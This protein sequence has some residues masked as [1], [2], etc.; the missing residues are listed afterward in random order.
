MATAKGKS[1]TRK[2][3]AEARERE[4]DNIFK[5]LG[6]VVSSTSHRDTIV[7]AK[8]ESIRPD[9]E[10]GRLGQQSLISALPKITSQI[11]A[12]GGETVPSYSELG[13]QLP[14]AA[15]AL[16]DNCAALA[17]TYI[18][19]GG[20]ADTPPK[21]LP[22]D[23]EGIYQ[24]KTGHRRYIAYWLA[25]PI[26][27]IGEI[28][29]I[30]D[31]SH[32][33]GDDLPVVIGRITENT[34]RENNS[35]AEQLLYVK[36]VLARLAARGEPVNKAKLSRQTGMERTRLSRL[37]DMVT[38]GAAEDE[39][40]LLSIHAAKIEDATALSMVFRAPPEDWDALTRELSKIGP[41]EFRAKYGRGRGSEKAPLRKESVAMPQAPDDSPSPIV[42]PQP[43]SKPLHEASPPEAAAGQGNERPKAQPKIS[44]SANASS[45]PSRRGVEV[46]ISD[47]HHGAAIGR[48][49]E[50]LEQ[51]QPGITMQA[52]GDSE[53]ERLSSLL[54]HILQEGEEG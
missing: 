21:V 4:A 15:A 48:L 31:K 50:L 20:Y 33:S 1:P 14:P 12:L 8:L 11:K 35:L 43:A 19:A 54:A 6:Q 10:N 3:I 25:R 40:R 29:V 7:T 46:K 17:N 53:A 9:P 39:E 16:Y 30:L 22:A 51:A 47:A 5:S 52:V 26:T 45:S 2:Q 24:T 18:P 38:A 23:E 41:A 44:V 37:V 36:Q 32:K 13:I 42:T 27:G 34:S 28:D 49:F